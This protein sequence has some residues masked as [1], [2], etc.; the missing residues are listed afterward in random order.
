MIINMRTT[1]LIDDKVFKDA[2][3]A[4]AARGTTLSEMV[5]RTLREALAEKPAPS[6]PFSMPV[7]GTPGAGPGHSPA[8]LATLRDDG[9]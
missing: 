5:T 7:Y 3:Q 1:L 8:D 6:A 4:A 2:K 9:R